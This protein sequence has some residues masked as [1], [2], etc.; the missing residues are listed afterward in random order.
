VVTSLTLGN[1]LKI[2]LDSSHTL[3]VRH[4]SLPSYHLSH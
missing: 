3:E 2:D 4:T 1:F